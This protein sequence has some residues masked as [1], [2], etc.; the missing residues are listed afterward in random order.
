VH[1]EVLDHDVFRDRAVHRGEVQPGVFGVSDFV[2][3]YGDVGDGSDRP[4]A[5]LDGVGHVAMDGVVLDEHILEPARQKALETDAIVLCAHI[6]VAHNHTMGV[7]DLKSAEVRDIRRGVHRDAI[8]EQ[9]VALVEK[10]GP[11]ARVAEGDVLDRDIRAAEDAQQRGSVRFVAD[12][13]DFGPD[14]HGLAGA[15][16]FAP[17]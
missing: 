4:G 15:V 10:R 6:A 11:H 5:E 13:A 8:D 1:F 16:D 17:A 2:V 14:V 7:A 9:V 3:A 12:L